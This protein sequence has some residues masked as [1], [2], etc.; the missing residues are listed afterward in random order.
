MGLQLHDRVGQNWGKWLEQEQQ[1][2]TGAVRRQLTRT[3][4]KQS[5]TVQSHVS[6]IGKSQTVRFKTD[7]SVVLSVFQFCCFSRPPLLRLA[8]RAFFYR[9]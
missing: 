6:R 1:V 8:S 7:N 2:S 4:S 3:L 5:N 9:H